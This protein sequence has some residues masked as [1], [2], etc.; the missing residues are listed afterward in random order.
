MNSPALWIDNEIDKHIANRLK[1]TD[2]RLSESNLNEKKVPFILHNMT[3]FVKFSDKND[4]SIDE[5]KITEK[6]T[7]ETILNTLFEE[8]KHYDKKNN[9]F[10]C[11]ENP[12]VVQNFK[13]EVPNHFSIGSRNTLYPSRQFRKTN[14]LPD[15]DERSE[16]SVSNKQSN[17]CQH[18]YKNGCTAT[19]VPPEEISLEIFKRNCLKKIEIL[20]QWEVELTEREINVQKKEKEVFMMQ[21]ELRIAARILNEKLKQVDQ[22]LKYQRNM[23]VIDRKLMVAQVLSGKVQKYDELKISKEHQYQSKESD[24]FKRPCVHKISD[25]TL[26]EHLYEADEFD[27]IN[28]FDEI[29]KFNELMKLDDIRRSNE[30]KKSDEYKSDKIKKSCAHKISGEHPHEHQAENPDEIKSGEINKLDEIKQCNDF[31][32]RDEVRRSNEIKK[33]DECEKFDGELKKSDDFKTNNESAKIEKWRNPQSLID[34]YE[35]KGS[36]IKIRRSRAHSSSRQS[37]LSIANSRVRT[38]SSLRYKER[39]K[40]SYDDLNSTLSADPGDSSFVRTSEQFLP[41]VYKKPNAFARST[42]VRCT[43]L[44]DN[45]IASKSQ[46]TIDVEEKLEYNIDEEKVLR[47]F[48]EN[49]QVSQDKNTKFQHYGLVNQTPRNIQAECDS[50]NQGVFSYLNLEV[51]D[52]H[53]RKPDSIPTTRPNSCN[54]EMDEWLQKKRLA[55]TLATTKPSDNKE[56]LECNIVKGK[57]KKSSKKKIFKNIFR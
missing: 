51:D 1:I 27:G 32:K 33:S 31:M 13:F 24:E 40:I 44:K 42:S 57:S 19:F 14:S 25:E 9:C 36:D 52:K 21:K 48:S 15:I 37:C 3:K 20:Q 17:F 23:Q 34:T 54:I 39:P 16:Y 6:R 56:N 45:A 41:H 22:Y 5:N 38:Y 29:K 26:D 47:R 53:I 28:I 7:S 30:A 35:E 18:G 12:G 10:N 4:K 46:E 11:N 43:K 50:H 2:A 55:Y 49:I 8:D